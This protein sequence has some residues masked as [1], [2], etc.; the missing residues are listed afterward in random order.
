MLIRSATSCPESPALG[1]PL[2]T[3]RSIPGIPL[4]EVPLDFT[5]SPDQPPQGALPPPGSPPGIWEE[6]NWLPNRK[7]D[8]FEGEKMG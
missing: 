3:S 5:A 2:D 7:M 4:P 1:P 6:Q 8:F